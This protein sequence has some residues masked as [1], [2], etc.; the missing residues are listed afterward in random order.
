MVLQKEKDNFHQ[1]NAKTWIITVWK[2][3]QMKRCNEEIQDLHENSERQYNDPSS[4]INARKESFIKEI[5]IPRKNQTEI[6]E[7]KNSASNMKNA[8]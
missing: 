6:V 3:I 8:L 4:K 5:E 1:L 7:V 2:I